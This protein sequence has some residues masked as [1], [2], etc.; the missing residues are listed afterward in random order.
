MDKKVSENER[1]RQKR[2]AQSGYYE[3]MDRKWKQFEE[4]QQSRNVLLLFE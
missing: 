3:I 1:V 4:N 2:V